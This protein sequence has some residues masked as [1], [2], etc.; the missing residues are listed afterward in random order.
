MRDA[1]KARRKQ[2]TRGPSIA[3]E[4]EQEMFVE[5]EATKKKQKGRERGQPFSFCSLWSIVCF[6]PLLPPV[7][8]LYSGRKYVSIVRGQNAAICFLS[9]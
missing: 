2:G 3:E 9:K 4:A 7:T 5:N 8:S 6:S 1:D